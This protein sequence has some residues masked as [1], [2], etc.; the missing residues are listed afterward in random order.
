MRTIQLGKSGLNVPVIAVGFMR[1]NRIEKPAAECFVQTALDLGLNF[2]DHADIYGDGECESIFADAIHMSSAVRE[3]ILLQS[4]C[5]I[6]KG[7]AFDFSKEHILRSVDGSLKRLKTEYL[8]VL[9]LHRPDALM[10]PEEVAEAFDT[11]QSAGKV[12]FFGVSNQN[13]MQIQLLKKVVKQPLVANQLQL[14]VT[15]ANMIT[16]GFHVN[17]LD[18]AA[19]NRDGSV[20]DFCRLNDITIQP[21]SPF[22]Y[23]F[24]DGV[25]LGSEKFPKLNQVIDGIAA[26]YNVSNTTIAM[27]WLL[28]HPANLQPVTGTMNPERL[29][30]CAKAA[31]IRL[32][33]EEWYQI[34]LAAGNILP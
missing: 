11:L 5:G 4:K 23:G 8:D 19:V 15:N 13:P 28:R 24:F 20:L 21:W 34:Y 12:R 29:Q 7:V 3:K 32:T 25:F 18:D 9:L 26:R 16:Q 27:A 33:R 22:Q 30:D 14:S 2:F 1:I 10:E 17:M 31:G 6:R